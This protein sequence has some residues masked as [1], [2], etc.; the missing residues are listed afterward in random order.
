[1]TVLYYLGQPIELQGS[2]PGPSESIS[3]KPTQTARTLIRFTLGFSG[4]KLV[5]EYHSL[6]THAFAWRRQLIVCRVYGTATGQL[7]FDR[8]ERAELLACL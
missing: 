2:A 8:G 4:R 7:V 6:S 1:M 3:Q 5:G